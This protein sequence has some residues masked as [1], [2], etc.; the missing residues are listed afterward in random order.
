M[1]IFN[2]VIKSNIPGKNEDLKAVIKKSE[3]GE[4][5]EVRCGKGEEGGRERERRERGDKEMHPHE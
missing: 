4:K 5:R 3:I 2:A 1:V